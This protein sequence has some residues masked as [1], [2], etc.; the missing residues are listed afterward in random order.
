MPGLLT[1]RARVRLVVIEPSELREEATGVPA[2]S[3]FILIFSFLFRLQRECPSGI[4][5]AASAASGARLSRSR[6]GSP[7]AAGCSLNYAYEDL[8]VGSPRAI[9][10][11]VSLPPFGARA[12]AFRNETPCVYSVSPLSCQWGRSFTHSPDQSTAYLSSPDPGLFLSLSFSARGYGADTC[13]LPKG[14]N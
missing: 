8:L 12:L 5:S 4:R 7:I 1:R 11:R 13:T 9:S 6:F 3:G 2:R 10:C 14:S